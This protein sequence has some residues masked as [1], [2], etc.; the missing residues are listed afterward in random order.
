M[1]KRQ[2]GPQHGRRSRREAV[3]GEHCALAGA[4]AGDDIVGSAAVEQDSCEDAA[5]D[6][7]QGDIVARAVHTVVENG[8]THGLDYLLER[9]FDSRIL[10]GLTVLVNKSY[11]HII[12]FPLLLAFHKLFE[13]L[14]DRIHIEAVFLEHI[15]GL[16]RT[17]RSDPARRSSRT[18]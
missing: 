13:A 6:I 15:V 1:C 14:G 8:M 10:C 12:A 2:R 5:L 17:G 7:G 4:A 16:A 11:F 3:A 18:G 9:R